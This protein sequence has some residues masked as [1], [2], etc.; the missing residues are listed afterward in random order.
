MFI[1]LRFFLFRES[2]TITRAVFACVSIWAHERQ[3]SHWW[4][5]IYLLL[6]FF[7]FIF[8]NNKH[9]LNEMNYVNSIWCGRC[10]LLCLLCCIYELLNS[11]IPWLHSFETECKRKKNTVLNAFS[12]MNFSVWKTIIQMILSRNTINSN[13][14]IIIIKL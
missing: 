5:N 12:R 14:I 1:S 4:E 11:Y 2:T 3:H 7:S 10:G 13:S 6:F 8:I 9:M